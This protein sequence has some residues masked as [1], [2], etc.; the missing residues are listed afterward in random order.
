MARKIFTTG[1][2]Q[3]LDLLDIKQVKHI[4]LTAAAADATATIYGNGVVEFV[5]AV[6]AGETEFL[7]VGASSVHQASHIIAPSTV[8]V[9]GAGAFLRIEF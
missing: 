9:T 8:D 2:G 3:S 4:T 1:A 7:N 6:K 5:I